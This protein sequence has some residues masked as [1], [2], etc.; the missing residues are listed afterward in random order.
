MALLE[1]LYFTGKNTATDG[2]GPSFTIMKQVLGVQTAISPYS[3]M[4]HEEE[5]S[6]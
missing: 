6:I 1:L 3:P 4:E 2:M 5:T